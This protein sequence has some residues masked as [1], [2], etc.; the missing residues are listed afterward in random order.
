MKPK[1]KKQIE[2][3]K[4]SN[5]LKPI[6]ETQKEWFKENCFEPFA[7]VLKSGIINC[8]ECGGKWEN[9]AEYAN[10]KESLICPHCGKI[11]RKYF[12]STR[13]WDNEKV[14]TILTKYKNYQIIRNVYISV[15]YRINEKAEYFFS[16]TTQHWIDEKGKKII[17]ALPQTT[18]FYYDRKWVFASKLEIKKENGWHNEFGKIY[19]YKKLLSELKR[20]GFE[21]AMLKNNDIKNNLSLV[22][23]SILKQNK[24]ETLLKMNRLDL[25]LFFLGKNDILESHWNALKI[26][27]RHHFVISDI[28][29]WVD[30]INLLVEFKEDINNPKNICLSGKELFEKHNFLLERKRKIQAKIFLE[31][32]KKKQIKMLLQ[33]K[34]DEEIFIKTHKKYFD[35][36]IVSDE[37]IISVL[38]S[39]EEFKTEGEK[40]KH[41]VFCN[42]Y[43]TQ[44][45]SLILTART[46]AD[47][48]I[49]TIEWSLPTNKIIQSR[50][51]CNNTTPYHNK[52]IEIINTKLPA[53]LRKIG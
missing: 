3:A 41:C 24:F 49:E 32:E 48:P 26:A 34:E 43:Y 15:I 16:E 21:K 40:L 6:N 29:L 23:E 22:F 42:K 12:S 36:L 52:I 20:N 28:D 38:K 9:K 47:E 53:I 1:T 2:V 4:F 50:G 44:E 46:Q 8:L 31:E 51:K 33:A 7:R 39:L 10:G 18:N 14:G 11:L 17:M 13:K 27:N 45:N 37:I 19:P 5:N 30:Y 35:I 25:F